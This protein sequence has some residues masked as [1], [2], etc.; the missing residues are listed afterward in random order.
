M[1]RL[2]PLGPLLV[3][4]GLLPAP[5]AEPEPPAVPREFRGVWVATV[6]NIDWPSAKGLPVEKQQEELKAILDK[7]VEVGLN[8][9]I[10]QVRPMADALYKSDLEPWSEFLTGTAGKAPEPFYDPLEFAVREAHARGLE[11]HA[12]LNP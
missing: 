12:W 5:A 1:R 6:G 2:L 9:V 11:L 4:A 7:C 8:A 10:L 3:L